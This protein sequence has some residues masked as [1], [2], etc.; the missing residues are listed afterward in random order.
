MTPSDSYLVF[1]GFSWTIATSSLPPSGRLSGFY[2]GLRPSLYGV[3]GVWEGRWG[4]RRRRSGPGG[5]TSGLPTLEPLITGSDDRRRGLG[6]HP[7]F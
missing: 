3:G 5:V 7:S 4:L 1:W 2:Q 6:A